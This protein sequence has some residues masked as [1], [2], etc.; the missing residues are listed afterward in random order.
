MCY[1][2][3]TATTGVGPPHPQVLRALASPEELRHRAASF[4][5]SSQEPSPTDECEPRTVAVRKWWPRA[6]RKRQPLLNLTNDMGPED[7]LG[8][9]CVWGS[10]QSAAVHAPIADLQQTLS[11][12]RLAD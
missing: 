8:D 2:C 1:V 4:S 6:D 3:I 7:D 12:V 11:R 9:G 5:G 10:E